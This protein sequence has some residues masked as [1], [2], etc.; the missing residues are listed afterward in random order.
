MSVLDRLL[1]RSRGPHGWPVEL[2]G[3]T[4]GGE[5]LRLRGL[6]DSDEAAFLRARAVN[7]DWLRPWDATP[8]VE[9]GAPEDFRAYR[10]RLDSEA[11]RGSGLPFVILVGDHLVGQLN[12]SSIVLGSFR[13]CTMGYWVSRDAAGRQIA[14]TAVALAG[15]HV[16]TALG[17]HRVEIN[18][19]PENAASLAVVR[20]LGFRDEG[21]RERYLH[22]D[23]D[24]R[25][26]RSFAVLVEDLGPGGLMQ[27]LRVGSS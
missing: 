14:P 16:L 7:A 10:A 18:I 1:G 27:R 23:G 12:V 2:T 15:D 4:P 5:P 17:L 20:K 8:P 19:R 24:W 9:G 26:H 22:I 21:V 13:S 11:R 3:V 25:D 6:R